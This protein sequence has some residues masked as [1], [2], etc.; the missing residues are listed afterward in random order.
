LKLLKHNERQY[1]VYSSD[2][3]ID[4]KQTSLSWT[5]NHLQG[6][7]W[8]WS[9]GNWIYNYLFNQCLSPLLLWVPIPFR[10]GVLDTTKYD[11]VCQWLTVGR[12]FS[13]GTPASSIDK[14]DCHKTKYCDY[15]V[16]GFYNY[17][18]H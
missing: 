9:Y 8:L 6:L 15:I 10:R 4:N 16:V 12:Q 17:L 5:C 1:F 18:C 3:K 2:L 11:K 13:L 7:S 14:T